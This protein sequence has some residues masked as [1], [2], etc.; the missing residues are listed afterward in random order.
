[1]GKDRSQL[2]HPPTQRDHPNRAVTACSQQW[3]DAEL[4]MIV[5]RRCF[6]GWLQA[7]REE[8]SATAT[9]HACHTH[10]ALHDAAQAISLL[11]DA[12]R[13][14]VMTRAITQSGTAPDRQRPPR[15]P[16]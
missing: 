8:R 4:A 3:Q 10:E 1:M 14:E 9:R 15:A 2:R 11:I 16:R 7:S 12:L 5:A 6:E 13:V